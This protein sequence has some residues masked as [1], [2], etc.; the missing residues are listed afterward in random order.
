MSMKSLAMAAVIGFAGLSLS[1]CVSETGYY[2]GFYGP[3]PY[4]DPYDDYDRSYYGGGIYYDRYYYRD[5]D[6]YRRR[7]WDRDR[8]RDRPDFNRP[9]RPARPDRSTYRSDRPQRQIIRRSDQP[10]RFETTP[11][12][13]RRLIIPGRTQN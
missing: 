2:E 8:D 9:D 6:R 11:E 7:H 5:R 10:I 4:Y 13:G 3:R 1:G 12:G